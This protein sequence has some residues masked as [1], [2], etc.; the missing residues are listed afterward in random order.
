MDGTAY[1]SKS[2]EP[3]NQCPYAVFLCFLSA[4]PPIPH[5]GP[6]GPELMLLDIYNPIYKYE[7]ISPADLFGGKAPVGALIGLLERIR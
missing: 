6:S 5:S 7:S 1:V 3:L 2:D 4:N